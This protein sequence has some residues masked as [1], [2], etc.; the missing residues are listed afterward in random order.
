MKKTILFP[1][2]AISCTLAYGATSIQYDATNFYEANDIHLCEIYD[3][4]T[5]MMT[6]G[7]VITLGF[8]DNS[9]DL[10]SAIA[11]G[12]LT[13]IAENFNS[14]T[15]KSTSSSYTW[16]FDDAADYVGLDGAVSSP[17]NTNNLSNYSEA[18]GKVLYMFIGNSDS[19]IDS[20]E[21]ALINFRLYSSPDT[22]FQFQALDETPGVKIF[23]LS[24]FDIIPDCEGAPNHKND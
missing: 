15:R 4:S 14:L 22:F 21:F 13:S 24:L 20:T 16:T 2:A 12:N 8:F 5:T 7:G 3:S 23:D 18:A 6:S 11:S 19:V 9:F 1:A 17:V 10:D